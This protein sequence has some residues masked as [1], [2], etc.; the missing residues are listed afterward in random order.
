MQSLHGKELVRRRYKF[1]L[2]SNCAKNMSIRHL[3]TRQSILG[4][5]FRRKALHIA[6]ARACKS[7]AGTLTDALL[8]GLFGIRAV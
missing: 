1:S 6:L 3:T 2:V 7:M 4:Q 5:S 8:L